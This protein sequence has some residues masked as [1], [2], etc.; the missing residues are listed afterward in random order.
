[1]VTPRVACY[2]GNRWIASVARL[3]LGCI[4][5][6]IVLVTTG[7]LL[8]SIVAGIFVNLLDIMN[9]IILRNIVLVY[10]FVIFVVGGRVFY[11]EQLEEAL[12]IDFL[13]YA[14]AFW[15]GYKWPLLLAT[16]K[17]NRLQEIRRPAFVC[18][19]AE[20]GLVITIALALV[21][22][23]AEV[24]RVGI[25][26]YLNG[27]TLVGKIVTYG[28]YEPLLG[29]M[30]I[31]TYVTSLGTMVFG[32]LYIG[33][34]LE[35]QSLPKFWLLTLVFIMLPLVKLSRGELFRGFLFLVLVTRLTYGQS[36]RR[37]FVLAVSAGAVVAGG[38]GFGAIREAALGL[39]REDST[40]SRTMVRLLLGELSPV[41]AYMDIKA[42]IDELGLQLGSTIVPPLITKLVPRSWWPEKPLN[43]SGYFMFSLYPEHAYS[44]F[45]LA[46][47][48]LGDLYLNFGYAGS[49]F[50]AAV[51]GLGS[52][53]IDRYLASG[54][55]AF[56]LP[57]LGIIL[58]IW[59][60]IYSILRN[61]LSDSMFELFS[62][63]IVFIIVYKLISRTT[64]L[65]RGT[66]Y[67]GF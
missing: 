28:Q 53:L 63:C 43:S 56:C 40:L 59:A 9:P 16:R 23:L 5:G 51:M 36:W 38:L 49:V 50:G 11:A 26:E 44:G 61:N 3:V 10:L 21:V 20:Y 22:Q 58:L 42:H 39:G 12:Q 30:T 66:R 41:I 46:P 31:V 2:R 55:R 1:M 57:L 34:C 32:S 47:T 24:G 17:I 45:F 33:A 48:F 37:W 29:T 6:L 52:K 19:V 35:R 7:S 13:I 15:V 4:A 65:Y 64:W 67:A 25:E 18:K 8:T 54:K 60:N 62:T 27:A 14:T